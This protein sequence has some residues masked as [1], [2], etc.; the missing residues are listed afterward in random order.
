MLQRFLFNFKVGIDAILHNKFRA[1]LTSLG[2]IFGVA[3]VISM[4]AVGAGAEKEILEQIKQVGSNNIIITA[5]L[6]TKEEKSQEEDDNKPKRFSTGLTLKDA[7]NIMAAVPSVTGISPESEVECI[8][9]A[10]G[11]KNNGKL[12]GVTNEYFTIADLKLAEGNF[13]TPIQLERSEPVCIIGKNI[14]IKFFAG[15]NPI[16]NEIKCGNIWLKIIGVLEEKTISESSVKS[17]SIRNAN[18]D[19][20]AP[21]KT[22]L[23]RYNNTGVVTISDLMRAREQEGEGDQSEQEEERYHQLDRLVVKIGETSEVAASEEIISRL[24]KRRHNN[25][26]D[27]KVTVPE[28]MLKQAQKTKELFNAVLGI[29]ASISLLVGG[30]GIMNIMLASVLERIREIGLRLSIGATKS[31]IVMQFIS[32]SLMISLTGGVLGV[33]LGLGMSYFVEKLTDIKTI[34]SPFS[35][36]ISFG[37]S[38]AIGL[39]FGIMP[40]RRASE[41]DPV[42]SMRHE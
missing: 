17:F 22:V 11:L 4:L 28:L 35:V 25:V 13:F 8:F 16:G 42:I 34:V 32:E 6:K 26:E 21:I 24:L 39:I 15:K 38:I 10:N 33:I 37:I 12:I 3:S 40:A 7:E 14:R 36:I 31:D 2:I 1:M 41:Q 19:I 18:M 27:F 30:I 23:M 20:Y 9:I 5:K 29:I